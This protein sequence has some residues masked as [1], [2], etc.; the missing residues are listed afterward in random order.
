MA[1]LTP[2]MAQYRSIK[3]RFADS[4]LF[5]RLGD[6]YEMF[7]RD[8]VEASSLLDLTLTQRAGVPMCGVPYHAAATYISRLLAAGRKVA[9]CEQTTGPGKGLMSRDV[10][11]VI[12]PGT[13]LDDGLLLRASNNYIVAIARAGD[14]ISLAYADV[15]TGELAATSFPFA[16]RQEI[17]KRELHRLEPREAITQESLLIEDQILR[18]LLGEREGLLVN[19]LPDWSFDAEAGRRRLE[20]QLGVANLKGYG[21]GP[22]SPEVISAGV[23]LEYLGESAKRSLD[24]MSTLTVYA[25]RTFVELDEASQ[26][27]LELVA[28]LQDGSR[29][30]SLLSVLDQTRTSPGA[31]RLRR[32]I[33]TP[34]KD[35][36]QIQRRLAAVESLY[37]DQV[38]LSKLRGMLGSVLDMER[39]TARV[40]MDKAHAKD[41]LAIAS[42]LTAVIDVGALLVAADRQSLANPLLTRR[43]EMQDLADLLTR[44]I[45][46]EPAITLNEGN[47]IRGGFD[48]EL[49]RLHSL[50]DNAREI[51]EK[52]L[53]EE[54]TGTGIGSLKLRYNRIIGY[55]F[56]VTKSNL[57][58]VPPHFIRRQSLVGGERFTTD[59]LADLESEINDASE[60]MVE[61]ERTIFLSVRSEVKK[62]VPWLLDVCEAVSDLDVF[63]SLAFAATVH[64]YVKPV[65]TGDTALVIKD[66]RHPVVEA[67]LP[68]GG[69]IP[70]SLELPAG[71]RS[72]VILTGPNMAGKSTFLRQV[73]L[74]TLMAHMGSF[75]PAADARIGL[76]DS[77]F[78]RVGASDNLA[79][80]ESTFLVEM[81][82]T[83]HI[84]RAATDRSLL[85][86][87][88]IGRGTS[89]SDGLAIARAVCLFI[90]NR[91]HARTLFATHFHELT[92]LDHPAVANLSMDV[93]D[94]GGEIVFL[95]RVREGPSSNSYGIH[96]AKLAGLPAEVLVQAE[97][98]LLDQSAASRTDPAPKASRQAS[99]GELFSPQEMVIQEI[100]ELPID[101]T[102]PLDAIN[103]IS[104]WKKELDGG[105]GK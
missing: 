100:R 70:N 68:G 6:F 105:G 26:R 88:E 103:R 75:V 62:A 48:A 91:I 57:P 56:E 46:D 89:T 87:D 14:A 92:D 76:V 39:L 74:I 50:K 104:R 32:W 2:M 41:L 28:N 97:R 73:A 4:I 31:R 35:A 1:E 9:I 95:K 63:Q 64:G 49:D 80:G 52:Y 10:Q 93:R 11:E 78:C 96:V 20:R 44:A 34:L 98:M 19:R 16:S 102:T 47:L 51:L 25:D 82:E 15:S 53:E 58:L 36:D 18:D 99:Q 27:N 30:F 55:S 59:R 5:F 37:H 84:L 17:L 69:F 71:G 85:I 40:A 13:V 7:D 43:K 33:L 79:R 90:L 72:F 60:R 38:L 83:A 22:D 67:H 23:L 29:K 45:C 21:L 3:E 12:T 86:M 24:H 81:N 77:I 54:R 94:Q 65:V 8:A 42:S 101:S 66:G 61:I